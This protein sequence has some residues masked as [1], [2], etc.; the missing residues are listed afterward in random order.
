[1]P[2]SKDGK[3]RA[4]DGRLLDVNFRMGIRDRSGPV[5]DLAYCAAC[6]EVA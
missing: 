1:M 4:Y 3:E 5:I 6:A 2:V